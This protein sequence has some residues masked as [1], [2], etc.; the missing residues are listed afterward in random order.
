MKLTI[1]QPNLSA[2]LSRVAN[3]VEKRNTIPILGNILLVAEGTTL[4]ATGTDMD[5]EV[6]TTA[7]AD[8]TQSGS[9]T[10]SAAM[11]Q[12]IVTKLAKGK[13]VTLTADGLNLSIQSGR[14]DMLLAALPID[15][16]PRLASSEYAATFTADQ[17]AIKRLFDLSAFAMSTEETRYYLQGVYLHSVD[18]N[19]RAV[20][21]DGHRLAKIDSAINADFPAVIVP[22]KT[23]GLI[24]SLLDEGSATVSVSE[25]KVKIDLGHTVVVSKVIDGTYPDY[26]RIIPSAHKTEVTV[27]AADVKQASALVSLVSAEKARAVKVTVGGDTLA[28]EV[29]SGPEVGREEVDYEWSGDPIECGVNAKYLAEIL[30]ACNGDQA[31]MRFQGAGDPIVICPSEDD[32]ALFLVMPLRVN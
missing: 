22:R 16:F 14:S 1:D 31:I 8:V 28:L 10:V 23:V 21:T 19:A 18:G 7:Q 17:M 30:Q 6:T 12:A 20:S 3:A 2:L 15:D 9:T 13:L 24:K 4:T 11:L 5:V 27:S 26:T 32:K 25:S 29:R